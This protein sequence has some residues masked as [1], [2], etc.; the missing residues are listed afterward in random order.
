MLHLVTQ[1]NFN[2]CYRIKGDRKEPVMKRLMLVLLCLLCVVVPAAAQD[3]APDAPLLQLLG[4]VPQDLAAAEGV[5]VSYAD[6][7]AM[8]L[9]RE[10]E[11]IVDSEADFT[12]M[13]ESV[14]KLWFSNMLRLQS[15]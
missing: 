6:Y 10:G 11:P 15:G 8:L 9:D 3:S 13:S 2:S 7:A 12:S 4:Y 1:Q 5:T 14:R